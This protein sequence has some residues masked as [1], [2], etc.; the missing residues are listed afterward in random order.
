MLALRLTVSEPKITQESVL[1]YFKDFKCIIASENEESNHHFHVSLKTDSTVD[2]VRNKMNRHF[3]PKKNMTYCKQDDGSYSVYTVKCGNILQNTLLSHAE[4]EIIKAQSY[5]KSKR[6]KTRTAILVE[7]FVP[8]MEEYQD[9]DF[10]TCERLDLKSFDDDMF[11]FFIQNY[12]GPFGMKHCQEY[13]FGVM[14][15][16][17]PTELR[18][19]LKKNILH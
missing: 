13:V 3:M 8:Q 1:E 17:K 2:A 10:G 14:A 5:V 4:L 6:A 18:K 7:T 16:H 15:I 19:I 11:D 12:N 9:Y